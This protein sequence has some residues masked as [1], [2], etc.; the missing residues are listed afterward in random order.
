MEWEFLA[1]SGR[2][3]PLDANWIGIQHESGR[4]EPLDANWIGIQ[5]TQYTEDVYITSAT[6]H[7]SHVGQHTRKYW[8][9]I[10]FERS[11]A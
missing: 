5:V 7:I 8:M 1:E 9:F 2:R 10:T 4:R 11:A 6:H 3:E